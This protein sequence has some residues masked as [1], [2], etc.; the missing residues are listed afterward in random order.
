M[1]SVINY[2]RV[3]RKY[4]R[5][6][7]RYPNLLR[8]TRFTEKV[9][10]AKLRWRTPRMVVLADKVLAKHAVAELLGIEWIT[11]TLYA[12][13]ALPPRSE[14]NWPRPYV[15]KANNWS[16]GNYFVSGP[17][18]P[19]WDEIERHVLHWMRRPFGRSMGE[20]VYSKIPP[21]ILV[22]PYI[23]EGEPP[24]DYRLHVF[25]GRSDFVSVNWERFAGLKRAN[26]SRDWQRLPFVVSDAEPYYGGDIPPEPK[27]YAEMIRAAELLATGFPF[28]RVD[29]YEIDGRPRFGEVTFYPNSGFIRWPDELDLKYGAMWPNR[30]PA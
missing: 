5:R 2:V 12:G 13:P 4:R 20:W 7:G 21:Q 8:P 9:Q 24:V 17:D 11:P 23:G 25:D 1:Q 10:V 30:L 19:D 18:E 29:F 15:I 22:E 14:R 26:Y 16:G 3:M 28:A 6:V 27:S